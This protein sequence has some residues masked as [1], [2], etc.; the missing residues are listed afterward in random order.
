[1]AGG[2]GK[3]GAG[4]AVALLTRGKSETSSKG[5][6]RS[7]SKGATQKKTLG[8]GGRAGS[9]KPVVRGSSESVEAS[10]QPKSKKDARKTTPSPPR[11]GKL[12][13]RPNSRKKQAAAMDE[14]TKPSPKNHSDDEEFHA[15]DA[16]D[17]SDAD[18]GSFEDAED[19]ESDAAG[20]MDDDESSETLPKRK[21]VPKQQPKAKTVKIV[22][23]TTKPK[24]KSDP[25]KKATKKA[26]KSRDHS[27]QSN[28]IR[29]E[30]RKTLE[31]MIDFFMAYLKDKN[32]PG[33]T[34]N[35]LLK[36]MKTNSIQG[37]DRKMEIDENI[38]ERML[39][40]LLRILG[41]TPKYS[42]PE[43]LVI[44]QEQLRNFVM[45]EAGFHFRVMKQVLKI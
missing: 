18:D 31:E 14:E 34:L 19:S 10:P 9:K 38:A 25:K 29:D 41:I 20:L 44:T 26:S 8:K 1:M 15:G 36:F 45:L 23:E 13:V 24:S 27:A 17:Q 4:K 35:S 39:L 11:Q 42:K 32:E 2:R 16:S 21:S 6:S 3:A 37:K 28:L 43:E 33:I 7:T 40:H 30:Q 5:K 22:A 12:R